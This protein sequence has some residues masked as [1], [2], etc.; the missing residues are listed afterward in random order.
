VHF[1]AKG[2]APL[3]T[4]QLKLAEAGLTIDMTRAS[5]TLFQAADAR[6]AS[7]DDQ[8]ALGDQIVERYKSGDWERNYFVVTEVVEVKS[9]TILISS[10]ADARVELAATGEIA[11]MALSIAGLDAGLRLE[12]SRNMHTEIIA[13]NGLTPLF[14]ARH[15]Q[16]KFL[17]LG[18]PFF[19]SRPELRELKP[20]DLDYEE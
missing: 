5:A 15:I 16:K 4:S 9:A 20:A 6:S 1:K 10:S 8:V 7:I 13:S 2:E 18:S 12:H 14:K 19:R 17:G 3:P 11:P